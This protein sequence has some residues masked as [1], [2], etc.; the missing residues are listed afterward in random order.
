MKKRYNFTLDYETYERLEQIAAENHTSRSG[1]LTSLIW[2]AKLPRVVKHDKTQE[3]VSTGKI[4]PI[5]GFS[6]D[7]AEK[8]FLMDEYELHKMDEENRKARSQADKAR[9]FLEQKKQ[10]SRG[11]YF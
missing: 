8:I 5:D 11:R 6:D 4:N 2:S 7:D 10:K 3:S 9:E 1:A